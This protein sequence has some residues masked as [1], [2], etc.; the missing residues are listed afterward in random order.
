MQVAGQVTD[1]I[2]FIRSNA[3]LCSSKLLLIY[4]WNEF[5][6]GGNCLCP[7]LGD[8]PVNDP[9]PGMGTYKTSRMLSTVGPVLLASG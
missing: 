7:T 9:P 8:P 1:A 2:S 4:S 5:D 6:E 3:Q